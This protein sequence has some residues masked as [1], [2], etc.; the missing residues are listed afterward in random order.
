MTTVILHAVFDA[1][2]ILLPLALV[3]WA[4]LNMRMW[5]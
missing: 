4:T 2:L 5:P 3:V 1:T